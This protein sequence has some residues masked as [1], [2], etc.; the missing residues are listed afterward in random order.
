MIN[1]HPKLL[2]SAFS[3]IIEN[4]M[5]AVQDDPKN[6]PLTPAI[7]ITTKLIQ[8]KQEQFISIQFQDTGQGIKQENL[9][10]V[11]DPFYTTK[12]PDKGTGLGLA[13]AL[14]LIEQHSGKI[15]ITSNENKGTT[16]DIHLPVNQ[17]TE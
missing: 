7:T 3:Y 6:P 9:K 15:S 10:Q 11:F 12:G 8:D 5:D 17:T 2:S 1:C 16:V 13:I 14:N 4:S